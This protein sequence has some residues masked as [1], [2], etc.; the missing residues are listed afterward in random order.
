[1][2]RRKPPSLPKLLAD[3]LAQADLVGETGE[4]RLEKGA[5][6]KARSKVVDVEGGRQRR[7]QLIIGRQGVPVGVDETVTFVRDARIP[8]HAEG[9]C[10]FPT[11]HGWYFVVFTWSAVA[12]ALPI[13]ELPASL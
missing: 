8:P 7:R 4:K 2:P 1:M 10:Y 12:I 9:V 5:V 6:L 13:E 11:P 3:L